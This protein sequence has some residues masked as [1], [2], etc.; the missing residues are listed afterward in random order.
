[1]APA[2]AAATASAKDSVAGQAGRGTPAA[3]RGRATLPKRRVD[4]ALVDTAT[5]VA[6]G[7]SHY[8]TSRYVWLQGRRQA[9]GAAANSTCP[10]STAQ[11]AGRRGQREWDLVCRPSIERANDRLAQPVET[12]EGTGVARSV[13]DRATG[14]CTTSAARLPDG[15]GQTSFSRPRAAGG[16]SW[17]FPGATEPSKAEVLPSWVGRGPC[18]RTE[19]P[20][21]TDSHRYECRR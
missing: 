2:V 3:L 5:T 12:I 7:S 17:S 16:L 6:T 9:I 19:R 10:P 20:L 21:G 11:S 15:N 4:P 14:L 1:M 18:N 13:G 8:E